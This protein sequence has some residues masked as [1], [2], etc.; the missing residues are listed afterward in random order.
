MM[1]LGRGGYSDILLD[2]YERPRNVGD[3]PEADT[4]SLVHN[5]ACG[6][7]V[8]LALRIEDGRIVEAKFRGEGCAAAVAA[9]SMLT[10]LLAG[11]TLD[12]AHG[13]DEATLE[14]HLGG[15]PPRR[16]HALAL[17]REALLDA[18]RRFDR[19]GAED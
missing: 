1:R 2:H 19:P 6:D 12:E 3:L 10:D 14:R 11:R 18:L 4:V 8:R 16:A 7:V 9:A 17:V 5:P 13:L 15:V